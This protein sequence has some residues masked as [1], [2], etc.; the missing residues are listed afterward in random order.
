VATAETLGISTIRIDK[1][2]SFHKA[3]LT[4][5]GIYTKE[6]FDFTEI[7]YLESKNR[8]DEVSKNSSLQK[9]LMEMVS[10]RIRSY[11]DAYSAFVV[12]DLG[13]GLFSQFDDMMTLVKQI[14]SH[15]HS[16]KKLIYIAYEQNLSLQSTIVRKLEEQYSLIQSDDGDSFR[17]I[18]H[19]GS[20]PVEI[21]VY[22]STADFTT[23]EGNE[24]LAKTLSDLQLSVDLIIGQ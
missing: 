17:G 5:L 22:V 7:Q 1:Q 11:V 16:I 13:A 4:Y 2:T 3:L 24:Y 12:V 21:E 10:A 19:V 20:F 15:Q 9:K 14:N 23:F 8:I 6:I 18:S